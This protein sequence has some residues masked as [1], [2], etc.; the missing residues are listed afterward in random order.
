MDLRR[1]NLTEK[2]ILEARKY[3][4][5]Q[6]FV[7]SDNIQTG[8]AYGFLYGEGNPMVMEKGEVT[9]DEWE[10]FTDANGRMRKMYDDWIDATAAAVGGLSGLS[11][12]DMGCNT[13]YFLYRFMEKGASKCVGYDRGNH[14][15]A[16]KFLNRI[17]G[18]E[19]H[20]VHKA[21]NPLTHQAR[22]YHKFD[23]VISSA[24]M[25]HLSDPLNYLSFLASHTKKAL[26]LHTMVSDEDA[27]NVAYGKPNRYYKNDP[28]PICFD[29]HVTISHGLLLES[30]RLAGFSHVQ[31]I[32]YCDAW[33]PWDWY[34]Y[35]KT[36]IALK[37]M[38]VPTPVRIRHYHPEGG[39]SLRRLRHIVGHK[40]FD[41][42]VEF[43]KSRPRLKS[44]AKRLG[45]Q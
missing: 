14:A 9:E 20:F 37:G 44:F 6:P 16:F 10:K 23:V 40:R 31:E 27:Y 3:L 12:A 21:Y 24:V 26:L 11:V 33:L 41:A 7:I 19:V 2:Q 38:S 13:G 28:F 43:V 25:C 8:V 39:W 45:F 17:T 36:F 34:H 5:Y 30:L 32:E 15:D 29:N 35:Q 42:L 1:Y 18:D 4:N 22:G